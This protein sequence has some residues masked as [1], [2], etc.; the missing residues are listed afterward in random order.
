MQPRQELPSV[1]IRNG[2]IYA[3]KR[4][5][6][7]EDDSWVGNDVVA[8]IMPTERSVNIDAMQDLYLVNSY[9]NN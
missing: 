9:M 7:M 2:A 8:Y 5:I 3:V 6:L 4:D 1:Y